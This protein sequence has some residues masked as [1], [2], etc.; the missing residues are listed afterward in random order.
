M[1]RLLCFPLCLLLALPVQ[2]TS[3]FVDRLHGDDSNNG[4]SPIS[5][6]Q[7]LDHTARQR[8]Q[9]G[10]RVLLRRGERWHERFELQGTGNTEQPIQLASY[11]QGQL[12]QIE[13]LDLR[14]SHL[15]V[16]ELEINADQQP[17]DALSIRQSSHIILRDMEVHNGIRD[18]IDIED[19]QD[20]LVSGLLIHHFLAGSFT[21]QHDA[22]GIVASNTQQLTIEYTEIHHTSGDSFQSDPKREAGKI[23]NDIV[24]RNSHFWTGP[25][26]EDFNSGW[27]ATAQLAESERQYPG[28]N[29][30][31]TKV[32]KDNW[33][34]APRLRLTIDGL[35]VHGWK[36][37]AYIANKAVFNLKEQIQANLN[38]IEV[39]DSE[40]AFRLRGN[41]GNALVS[42]ENA[43]IYQCQTGIRAEDGLQGLKV[44]NS[45]FG[46]Q[47]KES[48]N[49]IGKVTRNNADSWSFTGNVFYG[50]IPEIVRGRDN[51]E[52]ST[53]L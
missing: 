28:E 49:A 5:A 45:I 19:S 41:R 12:P 46:P 26:Q 32:V 1:I 4:L 11:G 44:E 7:S 22:H 43:H 47:L 2:A 51:L 27:K 48:V 6:W 30:I 8:L 17:A 15:Q 16:D 31:D 40:I 21:E 9:P 18:G 39:Y 36:A 10:D 29:A 35:R 37:D 52:V 20:I 3:Y 33:S 42:I 38:N 53:Q 34:N 24:I 14:G 23:S 25:L 13:G 50:S